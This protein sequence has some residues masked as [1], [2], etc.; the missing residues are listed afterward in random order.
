MQFPLIYTDSTSPL[1]DKLRDANHQ[2]PTLIDLNYDGDDDNDDG[3]DKISTNLTIMYRQL[4]SSGK[5]AR[6]FFGNSYRAGDEP[7]P[8]PGSLENVPHGT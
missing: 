2:P 4:V 8:G 7:D 3:I 6:L 1:Y 5:T